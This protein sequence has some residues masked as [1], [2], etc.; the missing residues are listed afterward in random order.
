MMRAKPA[1][2]EEPEEEAAPEAAKDGTAAKQ[3]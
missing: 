3:G 2:K 1:P